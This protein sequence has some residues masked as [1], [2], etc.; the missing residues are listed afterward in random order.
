MGGS[1]T[2]TP[3]TRADPHLQD[4]EQLVG[5]IHFYK[6]EPSSLRGEEDVRVDYL[7]LDLNPLRPSRRA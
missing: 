4:S 2:P 7:E 3:E 5:E 6:E 1:P